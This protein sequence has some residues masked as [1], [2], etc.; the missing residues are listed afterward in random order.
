MNNFDGARLAW[1]KALLFRQFL[2]TCAAMER[3]ENDPDLKGRLERSTEEA[4]GVLGAKLEKHFT[5]YPSLA[6]LSAVE[7]R[8]GH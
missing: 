2:E 7:R 6:I 4:R 8:S 5:L 3:C 1:F